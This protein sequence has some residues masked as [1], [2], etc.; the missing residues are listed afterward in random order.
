M[1][2]LI[3][4]E[5]IFHSLALRFAQIDFWSLLF[6]HILRYKCDDHDVAFMDKLRLFAGLLVL[7]SCTLLTIHKYLA[8]HSSRS[9]IYISPF[10]LSI[11]KII[12][13]QCSHIFTFCSVVYHWIFLFERSHL[14]GC[15]L[16]IQTVNRWVYS[17][18]RNPLLGGTNFP[19]GFFQ[20]LQRIKKKMQ[21]RFQGLQ[22]FHQ[23]FQWVTNGFSRSTENH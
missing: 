11:L 4:T 10:M 22:H 9:K 8:I 1:I 20:H 7:L 19:N 14:T 6:D 18:A 3:N 23:C 17:A 12:L 13:K 5:T 21:W 15:R 2:V 16:L